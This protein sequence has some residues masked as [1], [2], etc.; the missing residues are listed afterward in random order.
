MKIAI[1]QLSGGLGNQIF[2]YSFG[3]YLTDKGFKVYFDK[4]SGFRGISIINK[5]DEFNFKIA[6]SKK[7]I[8]IILFLLYRMNFK[9]FYF[10]EKEAFN[11]DELIKNRKNRISLFIGCW[12]NLKYV[13]S[14]KDHLKDIIFDNNQ[15]LIDLSKRFVFDTNSVAI[16]VRRGDYINNTLH[17]IV[18]ENYFRQSIDLIYK[19]L[20]NPIFYVFSDD[21]LWC[22]FFFKGSNFIFID[23][24]K[25]EIEDF[26]LI[27]QCTHKIISNST[28][29]WWPSYLSDSNTIVICPS[30]WINGDN[31]SN[32]LQLSNW[33]KI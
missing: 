24:T 10:L 1:V 33:I 5:L 13:E 23:F 8:S 14:F 9:S 31:S 19:K 7:L 3:K 22:K 17:E 28:F 27:Q 11:F 6:Y 26:Y 18:D 21:I 25:S 2:Q 15:S 30:K 20:T 12:Q 16:H 29:S 4:H 32:S